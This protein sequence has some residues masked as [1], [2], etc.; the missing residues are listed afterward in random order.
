MVGYTE[1]LQTM[2]AM[3]IFSMILLNAN[4]M[5]HRNTVM[6]VEGELEQEIVA[7]AQDIIEEGRTKEFDELSQE[8]VPPAEIPQDFTDPNNLGPDDENADSENSGTDDDLNSNGDY[9][10]GEF[11][12]FDDYHGWADTL[13]TE[14][15]EFYIRAEVYYVDPNTYQKLTDGTK[16]TFKKM[17]VNITSDFLKKNNSDEY[18]QYYLEF[19]R[20]YYAD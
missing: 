13:E 5:I 3:I 7:L 17:K 4:R 15:G 2:A 8:E 18:T 10:R 11:D 20:N 12:D 1:V 9:E 16:S 19:I 14:H 6:Q